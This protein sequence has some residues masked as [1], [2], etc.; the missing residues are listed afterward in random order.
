[1]RSSSRRRFFSSSSFAL[2]FSSSSF[3]FCSSEAFFWPGGTYFPLPAPAAAGFAPLLSSS[4]LRL[5]SSLRLS[6]GRFLSSSSIFFLLGGTHFW[7][8]SSA[9]ARAGSPSSSPLSSSE[10]L[11]ALADLAG[12]LASS[13]LLRL[14]LLE[15]G[16]A[17]LETTV[18]H[19]PSSPP[20][21][22]P[23]SPWPSSSSPDAF[24]PLQG[25]VAFDSGA[26]PR[27]PPSPPL[28]GLAAPNGFDFGRRSSS[29]R[30]AGVDRSS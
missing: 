1:M 2:A 16:A 7:G 11:S 23:A 21:P 25:G 10:S 4:G 3:L 27:P 22:A 18:S 28:R 6:D 8:F 17:F 24:L 20:P 26:L 9:L 13:S 5:S 29:S 15:R 19:S 12:A 30:A 14:V